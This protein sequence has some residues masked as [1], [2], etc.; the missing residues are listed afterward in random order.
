[1]SYVEELSTKLNVAMG[2]RDG[3]SINELLN[4]ARP[5]EIADVASHLALE[6]DENA[7]LLCC[8]ANL[9]IS[10]A[11]RG[12]DVFQTLGIGQGSEDN[13]ETS[14][15]RPCFT[16]PDPDEEG[17]MMFDADADIPFV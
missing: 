2:I 3:Q 11:K 6:G 4:C 9:M 1:M 5:S 16:I 7:A 8:E 12:L 15:D 17:F 14:D 10:Y 13:W